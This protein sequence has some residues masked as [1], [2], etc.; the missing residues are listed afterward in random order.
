MA[1]T[2]RELL[3]ELTLL[4]ASGEATLPLTLPLPMLLFLRIHASSLPSSLIPHPSSVQAECN[5]NDMHVPIL[6]L[7]SASG[8]STCSQLLTPIIPIP[9]PRC[10][11]HCHC[12]CRCHCPATLADPA[13]CGVVFDLFGRGKGKASRKGLQPSPPPQRP[14]VLDQARTTRARTAVRASKGKR[15]GSGPAWPWLVLPRSIVLV[16]MGAGA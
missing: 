7:P 14:V 8:L 5:D 16:L 12:H 11:C 2:T 3:W 9:T 15:G 6:N 4:F 13:R 10:R 1:W